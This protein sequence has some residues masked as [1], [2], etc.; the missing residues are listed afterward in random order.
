[1]KKLITLLLATMLSITAIAQIPTNGLVGYWPFNGNANDMSGNNNNGTV[2]GA[3]LTSDRCGNLNSAYVFN[4]I[5]DYINIPYSANI[6]PSTASV[7]A[8]VKTNDTISGTVQWI[9]F[10]ESWGK[11]QL[12]I[13]TNGKAVICWTASLSNYPHIFG[14]SDVD[15]SIWHFIVGEYD[16]TSFKIYVDGILENTG[17]TSFSQMAC[18][19]PIQIGGF[20]TTTPYCGMGPTSQQYVKGIIDDIRLYNRMLSDAEVLALFNELKPSKPVC[21]NVSR[22]GNGTIILTATGG[23]NYNWYIMDPEIRTMS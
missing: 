6:S 2:I 12:G 17:T 8:W 16:L 21:N 1:M 14:T 4:G 15:N 13:A 19:S 9:I 22:C 11:P 18:N 7:C 23:N 5:S 20:Y 10:G 3:T